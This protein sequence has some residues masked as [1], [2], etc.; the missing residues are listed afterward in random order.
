[1]SKIQQMEDVVEISTYNSNGYMCFGKL[2]PR[3]MEFVARTRNPEEISSIMRVIRQLRISPDN[4]VAVSSHLC[5]KA[6]SGDVFCTDLCFGRG[7]EVVGW[8]Y[9]ETTGAFF[10]AL[11]SAG[12]VGSCPDVNSKGH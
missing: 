3:G 12:L 4:M 7:K 10:D 5:F 11:D 8:D 6:K 2:E 1:M 9:A